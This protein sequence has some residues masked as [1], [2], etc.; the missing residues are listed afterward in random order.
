MSSKRLKRSRS[1]DDIM[2]YQIQCKKS[3]TEEVMAVIA[4]IK[5]KCSQ[6]LVNFES[7]PGKA[8]CAK[9]DV[10]SSKVIYLFLNKIN[11]NI[12]TNILYVKS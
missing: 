2:G 6:K 12:T 9:F 10:E 5:R 1:A 11:I 8:K 3:K 7:E 4:S